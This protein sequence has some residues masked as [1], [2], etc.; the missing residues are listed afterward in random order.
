MMEF[1]KA[2]KLRYRCDRGIAALPTILIIAMVILLVGIGIASSGFVE[3]LSSFGELE[4]K[5]ALFTAESGAR[6]AFKRI[7]RDKNCNS[8]G[9]PT[10][11][12]YS[13]IVGDGT[14]SVSITGEDIKTIISVGNVNNKISKIQVVVSFNVYG[15][16]TQTSWQQITN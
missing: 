2:N 9:T 14:A 16:A 4:N 5:K 15:K 7:V 12:S 8:G 3:N 6:D 10:C 1:Q 11:L 13:L